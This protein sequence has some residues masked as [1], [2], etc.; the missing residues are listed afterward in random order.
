VKRR[1]AAIDAEL[2]TINDKIN[3]LYWTFTRCK[4]G[5]PP[6]VAQPDLYT[7]RTQL[8]TER[9]ALLRGGK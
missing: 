3:A 9:S 4:R 1:I 5:V 6:C 7:R 8:N 2:R